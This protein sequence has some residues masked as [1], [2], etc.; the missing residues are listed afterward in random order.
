MTA[1]AARPH[2]VTWFGTLRSEQIKF[3][4]LRSTWWV[5]GV[6]I[7]IFVLIEWGTVWGVTDTIRSYGGLID[8]GQLPPD[9]SA[10]AIVLMHPLIGATSAILGVLTVTNEYASGMIRSTF[11]AQPGRMKVLSAKVVLVAVTIAIQSVV[12][13]VLTTLIT[14]RYFSDVGLPAV[15]F[16]SAG[17]WKVVGLFAMYTA[18]CAAMG[19]GIGAAIRSTA[20]SVSIVLVLLLLI[21]GLTALLPWSWVSDVRD[22]L[23]SNLATSYLS[24]D[25]AQYQEAADQVGFATTRPYSTGVSALIATAWAGVLLAIGGAVMSRRDA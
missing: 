13:F 18:L 21:S 5:L 10:F 19:I 1:V 24:P 14:G 23:P 16:A 20:G 3:F 7:A 2:R 9:F 15:D 25:L 4:S 11:T 8:Q 17:T 22:I 6:G 12:A